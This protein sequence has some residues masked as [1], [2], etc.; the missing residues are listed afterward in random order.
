MLYKLEKTLFK[1]G[2]FNK[3][4]LDISFIDIQIFKRFRNEEYINNFSIKNV[5]IQNKIPIFIRNMVS[6][7]EKCNT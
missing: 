1:Y 4:I 7:S 5:D 3:I 6:T 2:F